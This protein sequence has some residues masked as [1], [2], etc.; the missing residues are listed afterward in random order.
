MARQQRLHRHLLLPHLMAAMTGLGRRVGAVKAIEVTG[1][2]GGAAIRLGRLCHP[3]RA[4]RACGPL[5]AANDG[6]PR[7]AYT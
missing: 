4:S 7:G 6:R 5:R 1:S 3:K 2:P